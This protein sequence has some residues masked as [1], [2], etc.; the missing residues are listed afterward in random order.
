MKHILRSQQ[1]DRSALEKLF[2]ATDELGHV[3]D[4][5]AGK[6][7]IRKSCEGRLLFAIFYEASTRTRFSFCSAAHH[8]GMASVQTE[9]A[10]EFSS[11]VKGETL[12]DTIN[13]LCQYDP[14]IIVLRHHETGG[15]D[16]AAAV[17]DRNNYEVSIINAGDGKGQHPT[18]ALLDLYTIRR[19]LGKIDGITV[20]V[21]GD[22]A[23]GRTVRSLVYLLTKFKDVKFIF[24]SPANLKMRDDIIGHLHEHSVSFK[25]TENVE[26]ALKDADVAY[27]TR[28]QTERG[29]INTTLNLSL[30]LSEMKYM[31][32]GSILLHPLPRI[33]EIAKEVDNDTRAAYFR[34][35]R[36]GMLI[37]MSLLKGLCV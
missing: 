2:S 28:V 13:V 37:R 16:R 23:N 5:P 21:G 6:K 33:D 18:Q 14:D 3:Y 4:N 7:E 20:T 32:Q 8:I 15:A 27:W 11:A 31:K 36:N 24:L 25:E 1:F 9:N 29:S 35:V 22:L 12:E 30:G 17:I 34:Q 10:R 26:E 19:E